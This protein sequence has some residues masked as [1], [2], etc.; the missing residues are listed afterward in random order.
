LTITRRLARLM[1]GDVVAESAPG[2]GTTMTFSFLAEAASEAPRAAPRDDLDIR[3]GAGAMLRGKTV[4]VVDDIMVNRQ[5]AALF[6]QP[7]GARIVQASSGAEALAF[8]GTERVDIVLMDVQMPEMD[9]FEATRR[10]RA[11]GVA[12]SDLPIVALTAEAMEGDRERCLAAGMNDYAPKPL[13]ART[14]VS[15][16]AR[17]MAKDATEAA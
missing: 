8:L 12:G 2:K 13:D 9:G 15:A 4:L 11:L 14:L 5:V 10:I 17:A 6:L 16:M 7:F 1:D 3:R